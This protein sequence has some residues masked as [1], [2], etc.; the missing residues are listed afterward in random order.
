M[1]NYYVIYTHQGKDKPEHAEK[2]F[3]TNEKKAEEN[4]HK[5]LLRRGDKRLANI[6][7]IEPCELFVNSE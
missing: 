3:S 7:S 5:K 1:P 6:I 4:F 2:I